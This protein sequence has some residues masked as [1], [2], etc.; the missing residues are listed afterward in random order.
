MFNWIC[1][2][3]VLGEKNDKND[4]K[5]NKEKEISFHLSSFN[6][7]L[8]S[9]FTFPPKIQK[10]ESFKKK[11]NSWPKTKYFRPQ[12]SSVMEKTWK[13]NLSHSKLIVMDD[14]KLKTYCQWEAKKKKK[15]LLNV[16]IMEIAKFFITNP[17]WK[18]NMSRNTAPNR[19][20]EPKLYWVPSPERYSLLWSKLTWEWVGDPKTTWERAI[21]ISVFESSFPCIAVTNSTVFWVIWSLGSSSKALLNM[22]SAYFEEYNTESITNFA[23]SNACSNRPFSSSA[24]AK[25]PIKVTSKKEKRKENHMDNS[26]DYLLVLDRR[27]L[28]PQLEVPQ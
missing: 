4:F 2:K 17:R 11:E 22:K 10:L 18:E 5:E 12:K 6:I 27:V 3:Q 8:F 7:F 28:T 16:L 20:S 26:F 23:N 13:S 19:D 24:T 14:N 1:Y 21:W 15:Q 25:L 9:F